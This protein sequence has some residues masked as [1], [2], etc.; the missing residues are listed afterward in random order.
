MRLSKARVRKYRS[1]RDTGWFNVESG[2]TILVGPN[3]AGKTVVLEALQQLNPPEGTKEFDPI[4]DYP[5][6]E[7]NDIT[8][9]R[10]DPKDVIVVEAKFELEAKDEKELGDEFEG[11][12][13]VFEKRLDNSTWHRID[14]GPEVPTFGELKK[15]LV[16]LGAHLDR[17]AP[18]PTEGEEEPAKASSLLTAV[19]SGWSD[20]LQIK[21]TSA[22]SLSQWLSDHFPLIDEENE[23][24]ERRP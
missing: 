14:G 7:Y 1:I 16:R 2:K 8:A 6:S 21:G 9:G 3:E 10:V 17:Q 23:T 12:A 11:C 5:R 15:D 20:E 18:K 4:R 19:C 22:Q 24:E 13:Y